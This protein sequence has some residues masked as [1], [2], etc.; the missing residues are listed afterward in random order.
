MA[1]RPLLGCVKPGWRAVWR[2]WCGWGC[3]LSWARLF[4][5]QPRQPIASSTPSQKMGGR[6][7]SKSNHARGEGLALIDSSS[8]SLGPRS[9]SYYRPWTYLTLSLPAPASASRGLACPLPSAALSFSGRPQKKEQTVAHQS[10][11]PPTWSEHSPRG[12][13]PHRTLDDP[14]FHER[15][16]LEYSVEMEEIL[17]KTF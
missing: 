5:P 13:T 16:Y 14:F 11:D 8:V 9:C 17:C 7:Q 6:N 10:A 4:I 1:E 12:A 15:V 3:W 2:R